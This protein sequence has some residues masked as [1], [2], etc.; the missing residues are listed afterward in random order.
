MSGYLPR[1][2]PSDKPSSDDDARSLHSTSARLYGWQGAP[3]GSPGTGRSRRE[4]EHLQLAGHLRERVQEGVPERAGHPL[5]PALV[6]HATAL[7][8]FVHNPPPLLLSLTNFL[9][10]NHGPHTSEESSFH[11]GALLDL[12]L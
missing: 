10:S 4:A 7:F 5:L 12:I 9:N 8:L 1:S 2:L 6:V 11:Y 3:G